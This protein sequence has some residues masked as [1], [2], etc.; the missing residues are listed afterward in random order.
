MCDENECL[1]DPSFL[2]TIKIQSHQFGWSARNYSEFWGRT[3]DDGL[4]WRLGTLQS[5][6]KVCDTDTSIFIHKKPYL[7]CFKLLRYFD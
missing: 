5:P 2:N 1:I 7:T 4:K 3:Y 6:E